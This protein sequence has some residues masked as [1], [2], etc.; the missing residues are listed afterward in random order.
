MK[1]STDG[2]IKYGKITLNTYGGKNIVYDIRNELKY[3]YDIF[4][5]M[6]VGRGLQKVIYDDFE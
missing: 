4:S 2:R 1:K 3:T 5:T 6:K